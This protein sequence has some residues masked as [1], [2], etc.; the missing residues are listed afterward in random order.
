MKIINISKVGYNHPSQA[1]WSY[2]IWQVE[3]IDS[4][5]KYNMAYTTRE[6]FG[7]DSRFR[8]KLEALKIPVVES[9]GIYTSTGT[10][11]ITGVRSLP[12]LESDVF[13][14]EVAEWYK[15]PERQ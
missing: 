9:K 2:G 5:E 15:K 3:L 1:N 7:G 4:K 12:D 8:E 13:V 6:A 10:Q 11:K 14:A